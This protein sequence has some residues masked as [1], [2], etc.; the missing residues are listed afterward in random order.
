MNNLYLKKYD[1]NH[2][3]DA[4]R[5]E[6][7]LGRK[8]V[9]K[10]TLDMDRSKDPVE[11]ATTC[12]HSTQTERADEHPPTV[13]ASPFYL[14]AWNVNI[15]T[16]RPQLRE[17]SADGASREEVTTRSQGSQTEMMAGGEDSWSPLAGI[18]SVPVQVSHRLVQT[19]LAMAD[20]RDASA[21]VDIQET[22]PQEAASPSP[23]RPPLLKDPS[24]IKGRVAGTLPCHDRRAQTTSSGRQQEHQR[25]DRNLRSS[26]SKVQE[27]GSG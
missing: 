5:D 8:T 24:V 25:A 1:S 19:D 23:Q 7:D 11:V 15:G 27:K 4:A 2:V 26:S 21:L 14:R 12:D 3:E 16:S 20:G 22:C 9:V 13:V 6:T 18:L 10:P 17:G